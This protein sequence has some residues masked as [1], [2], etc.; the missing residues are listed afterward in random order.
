[1]QSIRRGLF[2]LPQRRLRL[3]AVPGVGFTVQMAVEDRLVLELV[4]PKA[5]GERVLRPDDLRPHD[6]T[7]RFDSA[8]EFPLKR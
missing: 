7:G 6:K 8:L 1:M 3:V 4:A 2:L 5:P